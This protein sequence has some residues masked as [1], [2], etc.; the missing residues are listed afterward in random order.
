[1]CGG[2]DW[3]LGIGN[4][5]LGFANDD[6]VPLSM[7]SAP[8]A[9]SA[10]DGIRDRESGIRDWELG[11][12]NDRRVLYQCSALFLRV[13]RDRESGIRDWELGF[14]NDKRVLYQC[15]AVFLRI[16]RD[17]SEGPCGREINYRTSTTVPFRNKGFPVKS[18]PS[19]IQI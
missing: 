14:A 3:G 10:G 9:C 16:L 13:L 18:S 2:G 7:F 19:A 1:M 4:L 15:S 17:L 12:A 11:F 8:S 6:R 5:E